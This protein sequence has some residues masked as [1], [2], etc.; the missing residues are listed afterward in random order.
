MVAGRGVVGRVDVDDVERVVGGWDVVV[1][2]GISAVVAAEAV[3]VEYSRGVFSGVCVLVEG[4]IP[5]VVAVAVEL[6]LEVGGE[7][8]RG[9]ISS[10]RCLCSSTP[11]FTLMKMPFSIDIASCG[12]QS[13]ALV[14][15]SL[16][17]KEKTPWIF[18]TIA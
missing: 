13:P 2:G 14:E 12:R 16:L 8:S 3:T 17:L 10:L 18:S 5:A 11:G 1:L 15:K 7:Y 9:I 4:K 6:I